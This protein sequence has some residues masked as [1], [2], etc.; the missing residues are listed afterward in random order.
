MGITLLVMEGV[1]AGLSGPLGVP[2]MIPNPVR[3]LLPRRRTLA[4]GAAIFVFF[5]A[6]SVGS[7]ASF[8][9]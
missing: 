5:G 4:S 3:I 8:G 7:F 2:C 9:I 6:K 1:A